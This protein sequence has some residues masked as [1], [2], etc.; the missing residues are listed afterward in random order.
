MVRGIGKEF[1]LGL[2]VV[3]VHLEEFKALLLKIFFK[4]MC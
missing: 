2:Y 4:A 1:L 3:I